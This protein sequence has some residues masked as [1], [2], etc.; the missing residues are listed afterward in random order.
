MKKI[1]FN[2]LIIILFIVFLFINFMYFLAIGSGHKIPSSISNSFII[3][4]L[5]IIALL[6]IVISLKRKFYNKNDF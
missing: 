6:L 1:I 3:S 4:N 2:I 5:I